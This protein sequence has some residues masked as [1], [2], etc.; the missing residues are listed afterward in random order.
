MFTNWSKIGRK[1]QDLAAM[2]KL[3]QQD[4]KSCLLEEI[5][6]PAVPHFYL[7][8]NN[9]MLLCFTKTHDSTPW[10]ACVQRKLPVK[11]QASGFGPHN[12]V[13]SHILE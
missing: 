3:A 6:R 5:P 11:S 9:R 12:R 13:F 2:P 10:I 4:R 8:I 1:R 7:I